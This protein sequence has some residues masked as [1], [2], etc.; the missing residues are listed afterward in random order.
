MSAVEG[1]SEAKNLC[2]YIELERVKFKYKE[3]KD[4]NYK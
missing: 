3:Y 4:N 1:L 2:P